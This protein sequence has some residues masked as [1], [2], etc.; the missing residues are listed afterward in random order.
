[1]NKGHY[2]IQDKYTGRTLNVDSFQETINQFLF[3]GNRLLIEFIPILLN[4]LHALYYDIKKMIGYRFYGASLLIVYDGLELSKG[5][6]MKLIDFT[7]C[8]TRKEIIEN[9]DNMTYPPERGS[10]CPDDGFLQG[11]NTLIDVLSTLH[12]SA[13]VQ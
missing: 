7:H 10:F 2:D 5:I 11:I 12:E 13:I 9:Q 3:N 4:K 8:I 1:V 6:K